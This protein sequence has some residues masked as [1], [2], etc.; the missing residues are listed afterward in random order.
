MLQPMCWKNSSKIKRKHSHNT[1]I[2]SVD[3]P[4]RTRDL[5]ILQVPTL[6][7]KQAL[8]VIVVVFCL[9]LKKASSEVKHKQNFY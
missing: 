4:Q 5:K 8:V 7:E 2:T 6:L 1:C 9:D 3:F